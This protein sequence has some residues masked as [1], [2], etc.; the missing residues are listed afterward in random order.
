MRAAR[1]LDL[2]PALV[3]R[4]P[5]SRVLQ[6]GAGSLCGLFVLTQLPPPAAVAGRGK[7]TNSVG[8]GGYQERRRRGVPSGRPC[9]RRAP[10]AA[11]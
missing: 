8:T 2:S 9:R 10:A 1:S 3:I 11:D 6:N 4:P 7:K 5:S